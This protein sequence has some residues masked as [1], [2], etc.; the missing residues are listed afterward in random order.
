[1]NNEAK[2][3]CMALL[4]TMHTIISQFFCHCIRKDFTGRFEKMEYQ[5]LRTIERFVEEKEMFAEAIDYDYHKIN[6]IMDRVQIL[7]DQFYQR[8]DDETTDR[9]A[10][11]QKEVSQ[12]L[13]DFGFD[14][15]ENQLPKKE[16]S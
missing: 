7:I 11:F 16:A 3:E 6:V 8:Y 12:F 15:P 1:M 9:K 10:R 5:Q 13:G 2:A 4:E 14:N